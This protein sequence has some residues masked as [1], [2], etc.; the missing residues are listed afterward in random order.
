VENDT[1][2]IDRQD[3]QDSLET[4]GYV[5]LIF[6]SLAG[7]NPRAIGAGFFRYLGKLAS[8]LS[9]ASGNGRWSAFDR[10]VE[11]F[12]LCAQFSGI[13]S[14]L[15]LLPFQV[16]ACISRRDRWCERARR[17]PDDFSI[18][19]LEMLFSAEDVSFSWPD[20]NCT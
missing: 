5:K 19:A 8:D 7:S 11:S 20:A 10:L 9:C 2:K 3:V 13:G 6:F 15:M 4:G 14:G 17:K 16:V 1:M 12:R 18:E